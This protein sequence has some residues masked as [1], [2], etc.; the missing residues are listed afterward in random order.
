MGYGFVEFK[1]H[2]DAMEVLRAVNNN[3]NVFTRDKRYVQRGEGRPT[4]KG[5]MDRIVPDALLSLSCP[6]PHPCAPPF[7]SSFC[8]FFF[9]FFFCLV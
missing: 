6:F 7:A 2:E 9:F 5:G 8:F 3:P 4:V 1:T